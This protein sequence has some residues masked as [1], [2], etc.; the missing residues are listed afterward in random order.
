MRFGCVVFLRR[1]IG[2]VLERENSAIVI[3]PQD[4]F[5]GYADLTTNQFCCRRDL[6]MREV[7]RLGIAKLQRSRKIDRE[8]IAQ[9]ILREGCAVTIGNLAARSGDIENVSARQ[10]LCLERRNDLLIKRRRRWLRRGRGAGSYRRGCRCKLLS[11]CAGKRE[12]EQCQI[13]HHRD[14]SLPSR[15]SG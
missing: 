1:K 11:R 10:F 14:T 8:I 3:V 5:V 12:K 13:K 15:G 6:P 2:G 4:C 9:L 7:E